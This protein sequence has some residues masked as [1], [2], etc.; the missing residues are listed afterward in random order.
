[1]LAWAIDENRSKSPSIT[2]E[3]CD[4]DIAFIISKIL[5]S[6]GTYCNDLLLLVIGICG[7]DKNLDNSQTTTLE[8]I[9]STGELEVTY[10]R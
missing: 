7:I 1:M 5:I 10:I 8:I 3:S 9:I 6:D 4:E 2:C